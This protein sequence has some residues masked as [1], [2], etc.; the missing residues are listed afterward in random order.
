MGIPGCSPRGLD[1]YFRE[2]FLGVKREVPVH[3]PG[4]V[5]G[6]FPENFF[7]WFAL[8]LS[9]IEYRYVLVVV[10][11]A[12]GIV[13][14]P[15]LGREIGQEGDVV[16]QGAAVSVQLRLKYLISGHGVGLSRV[17]VL[18]VLVTVEFVSCGESPLLHLVED[19]LHVHELA[20]AE[21]EVHSGTEEF[22][23]E[24]RRY[25]IPPSILRGTW[26]SGRK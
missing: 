4:I 25:R 15:G 7:D 26:Q 13:G 18:Q 22:L 3:Y 23:V 12:S 2:D 14:E 10:Y 19:I 21:I 9:E 5:A 11:D 16:L 20:F 8:V 17:S 24:Q 6:L 1:L